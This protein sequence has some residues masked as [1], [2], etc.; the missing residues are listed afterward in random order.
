M[1]TTQKISQFG[2][3][4]IAANDNVPCNKATA[5]RWPAGVQTLQ[6]LN[7]H[8]R[9]PIV[10]AVVFREHGDTFFYFLTE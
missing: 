1:K 8:A 5:K 10:R 6:E 3:L 2:S 9:E 4:G 7:R